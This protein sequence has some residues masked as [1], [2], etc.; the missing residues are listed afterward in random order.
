MTR[1]MSLAQWLETLCDLHIC[2]ASTK[3]K[4]KR[5]EATIS[6]AIWKL[7]AVSSVVAAVTLTYYYYY[8]N[9]QL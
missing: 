7:N 8:E 5:L 3:M 4:L 1:V 9:R 2:S 6:Y